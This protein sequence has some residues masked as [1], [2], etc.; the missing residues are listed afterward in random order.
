MNMGLNKVAI[1]IR[2]TAQ[3]EAHRITSEA[4]NEGQEIIDEARNR[5]K[6]Q[7]SLIRSEMESAFRQIEARNQ[8]LIR[9]RMKDFEMNAKKE[10]VERVY[11]GFMENLK[12]AKTGERERMFK[13]MLSAARKSIEKPK[14]VYVKR[15]DSSL[16]RKM[17]RGL[18]VKTKEMDGGLVLES[19]DAKEMIDFRFE[20]LIDLMKS[21]TLKNVSRMLFGE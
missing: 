4:K 20:T 1:E 9:K 17:F 14:T 11:Q 16:A 10:L 7:E 18:E 6:E 3:K 21:R 2:V 15:E 19:S 8:T 12:K 5:V 13:R